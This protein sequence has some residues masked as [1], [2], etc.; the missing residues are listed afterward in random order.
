M[1]R[2]ID[3]G[4]QILEG[5]P[6]FAWYTTITDTFIEIGGNQTWYSWKDFEEDFRTEHQLGMIPDS[7][8][9]ERFLGLFP[10][11]WGEKIPVTL[12]F[13]K[14]KLR[15]VKEPNFSE[16]NLETLKSI[17][18]MVFDQLKEAVENDAR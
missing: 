14:E 17:L 8:T 1:I 6:E 9:I 5:E 3:L 11:D 18:S 2:F 7:W 4:D 15:S 13:D 16:E 10:D 12:Y